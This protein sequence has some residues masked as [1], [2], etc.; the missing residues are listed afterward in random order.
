M[1]TPYYGYAIENL[2]I[3]ICAAFGG[4]QKAVF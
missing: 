4:S 3:R 2:D 1:Q